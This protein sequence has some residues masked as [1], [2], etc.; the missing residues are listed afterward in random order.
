MAL[1]LQSI[2]SSSPQL[3][4]D[5]SFNK[6]QTSFHA[7]PAVRVRFYGFGANFR[8]IF[9]QLC[10]RDRFPSSMNNE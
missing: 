4:R 5:T 6:L 2:N 10:P 9:A 3:H 1:K 8:E 7:K